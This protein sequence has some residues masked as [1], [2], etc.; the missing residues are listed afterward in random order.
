MTHAITALIVIIG[1]LLFRGEPSI[2]ELIR[3]NVETRV[4]IYAETHPVSDEEYAPVQPKEA[5]D[6]Q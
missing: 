1:I 4:H 6:D 2:A 3:Q 5:Q